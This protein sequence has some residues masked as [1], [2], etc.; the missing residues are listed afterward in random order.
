MIVVVLA[1]M[2]GPATMAHFADRP[3]MLDCGR[4][5]PESCEQLW[6]GIA[7]SMRW[8]GNGVGPATYARFVVSSDGTCVSEMTME[9]G[10]FT[11]GLLATYR[12]SGVCN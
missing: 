5:T 8:N 10:T 3:F 4:L 2:I 9:R 11:F 7:R 12:G 6:R 1:L